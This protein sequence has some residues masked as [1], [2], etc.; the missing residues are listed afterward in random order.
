M[1]DP[2][3]QSGWEELE[4]E[5]RAAWENSGPSWFPACRRKREGLWLELRQMK[6]LRQKLASFAGQV[7]D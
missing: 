5:L 1:E 7:R 3:L 2:T 6:A 4:A